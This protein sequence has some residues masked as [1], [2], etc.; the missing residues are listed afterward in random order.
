[1]LFER[2]RAALRTLRVRL[3]IWGM[4]AVFV[5]VGAAMFLVRE[6]VR[7]ELVSA[8]DDLLK[9]EARQVLVA[10]KDYPD[11]QSKQTLNRTAEHRKMDLPEAH[12]RDWFVQVFDEDGNVLWQTDNAPTDEEL[13]KADPHLEKWAKTD[14]GPYRLIYFKPDQTSDQKYYGFRLGSTKEPLNEEL[15]KVNLFMVLAM[16]VICLVTPLGAYIMAFR[17][18]QPVAKIIATTARLEPRNLTE[19]LP[20]QGTGDEIDQLSLTING[21]LDR[22]ASFIERHREFIADAAHE[23]RSPL[24]A[25]RSSVEVALNRPRPLEEYQTL[26]ADVMEECTSLADLVNRLLLLAE[27]DS[28]RMPGRDKTSSLDKLVRESLDMFQPVAEA[29]GVELRSEGI[30]EVLV[31]GDEPHLRQIVRNLIDNAVKFTEPGGSVTVSVRA[32]RARKQAV[33][34]VSDTGVGIP[35]ENLSRIFTRFFRGDKSRHRNEGP[36]GS[37][38]GL[39]ICQSITKALNG[40]IKVVSELGRGSTFTVTL[41]QATDGKSSVWALEKVK[42]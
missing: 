35:P 37:G 24:T 10:L 14:I 42:V 30:D 18:V 29:H 2:F 1:M 26:L 41:P 17:A 4:L 6:L 5:M 11:K 9:A 40:D 25:I 7:N 38:L 36:G 12:R 3:F 16:L 8:F 13:R 39:S 21:M 22:I 32:E 15:G 20:I 23:L 28:G 31:P 19:R 34:T 33:L 27:G